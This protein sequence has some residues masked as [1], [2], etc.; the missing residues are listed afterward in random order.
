MA[1]VTRQA[2][3]LVLEMERHCS[4]CTGELG[5]GGTDD[6]A[7]Q[8]SVSAI[9]VTTVSWQAAMLVLQMRGHCS[10]C[11]TKLEPGARANGNELRPKAKG[12]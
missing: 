11:T 8:R 12:W 6:E 1:M 5:P 2:G 7:T 10:D 4:D 9:A 3:I